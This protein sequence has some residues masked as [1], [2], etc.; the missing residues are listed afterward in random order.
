MGIMRQLITP[1]HKTRTGKARRR[2][3]K[4]RANVGR[5][6]SAREQAAEVKRL[7]KEGVLK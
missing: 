2:T 4:V 5:I 3:A 1:F 6:S 7:K